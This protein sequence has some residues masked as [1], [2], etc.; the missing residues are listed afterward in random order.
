M[1]LSPTRTLLKALNEGFSLLPKALKSSLVPLI[2]ILFVTTIFQF[3]IERFAKIFAEDD[4]SRTLWMYSQILLA[5][6]YLIQSV[7][8]VFTFVVRVHEIDTGKKI[9]PLWESIAK[10]TKP[11]TIEGLRSYARIL[12]WGLV[13]IVPGFV[14]IAQYSLV[15]LV[16][17]LDPRYDK[18]EVDALDESKRIMK[19]LTPWITVFTIFLLGLGLASE[20]LSGRSQVL[21][22]FVAKLFS[23]AIGLVWDV[24]YWCFFYCIF[25]IRSQTGG[26]SVG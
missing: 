14:K 13:L 17:A 12:L 9:T 7:F 15:S 10:L 23:N 16:V 21:Q 4:R 2:V 20:V 18:G 3:T 8:I 11:I 19:G 26:G 5:L 22:S 25:K 6:V 24:F 1:H